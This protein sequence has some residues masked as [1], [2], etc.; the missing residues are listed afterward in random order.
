MARRGAGAPA[1]DGETA[2]RLATRGT[3]TL[4]GGAE[5]ERGDED[6]GR[7]AAA[8]RE[9]GNCAG[10]QAGGGGGNDDFELREAASHPQNADMMLA[11]AAINEGALRIRSENLLA[12][13]ELG[14]KRV[15]RLRT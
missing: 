2:R 11:A 13:S 7:G 8:V 10:R 9:D 5:A 12:A 14:P 1:G 15:R 6:K 3:A 4:T